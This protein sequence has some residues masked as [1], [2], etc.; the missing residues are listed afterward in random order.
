MPEHI[1]ISTYRSYLIRLWMDEG[2]TGP[3]TWRCE[4]HQIQGGRQLMF[5]NPD[6]LLAFLYRQTSSGDGRMDDSEAD[7][8]KEVVYGKMKERGTN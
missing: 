3:A 5:D 6:D 1:S 2:S 8:S 4:V 7:L